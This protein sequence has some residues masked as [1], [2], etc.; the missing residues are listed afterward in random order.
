[1]RGSLRVPWHG[2]RRSRH[3]VSP[4]R[5]SRLSLRTAPRDRRAARG[6]LS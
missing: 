5:R 6:G 3:R 4:A 2:H 1:L